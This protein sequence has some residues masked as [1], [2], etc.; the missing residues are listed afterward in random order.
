MP[1]KA[2]GA[3]HA[4]RGGAGLRV[5]LLRHT[6]VVCRPA[7]GGLR[8]TSVRLRRAYT[9]PHTYGPAMPSTEDTLAMRTARHPPAIRR[10]TR[11]LERKGAQTRPDSSVMSP[12]RATARTQ[13]GA[14]GRG[15]RSPCGMMYTCTRTSDTAHSL[16]RHHTSRKRD[17]DAPMGTACTHCTHG[18]TLHAMCEHTHAASTGRQQAH[19]AHTHARCS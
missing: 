6:L 3:T 12:P 4:R 17:D 13:G 1:Q 10:M 9:H 7:K 19:T 18:T 16:P 15:A 2:R 11:R 5:P 8:R 14:R